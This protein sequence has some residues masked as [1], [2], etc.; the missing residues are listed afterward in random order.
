MDLE[1]TFDAFGETGAAAVAGLVVGGLFGV[2]AQRSRFCLR[3]A[4]VE[5]A[6]GHIAE[7]MAIWLLCFSTAL[8]WT[9]LFAVK[10]MVDLRNARVLSGQGSISGA[11]IGGLMVGAGMILARGCSGRL[12]V[13]AA[14]GNLR[15]LLTGLVFVVAAQTA[16]HGA[17]APLRDRIAGAW[18]TGPSNIELS[19]ALGLGPW[20]G[21]AAGAAFAALALAI[22]RRARVSLRALVFGSGVGFAVGAGWWIT[23]QLSRS[24]FEPTPVESLTFSGPSADTLMALLAQGSVV[25]FGVGMIAGVF[26]GAF[27]AALLTGEARFEGFDGAPAMRRHI[28]GGVLMGFGAMLAGGCA[29]GAGVTGASALSATHWLALVCIW[30]GAVAT[31]FVVDRQ[32]AARAQAA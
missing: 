8:F 12:L 22:A 23:T 15:S 30:V 2:S 3:A 28:L 1:W 21:V 7:R 4:A 18:T 26:G 20:S 25:D 29:I 24:A 31:D 9:Q 5:F 16:Y 19:A 10:G 6:R 13:L 27:L 17:L 32:P 14:G 11:I